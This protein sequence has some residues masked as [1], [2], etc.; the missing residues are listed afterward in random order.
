MQAV[1]PRPARR[2]VERM[3][4]SHLRLRCVGVHVV[5]VDERRRRARRRAEGRRWTSRMPATP[6]R[7]T[8]GW[9]VI[10]RAVGDGGGQPAAG[11]VVLVVPSRR[12]GSSWV[13]VA[14]PA[15]NASTS[16]GKVVAVDVQSIAASEMAR[17][18]TMR[19]ERLLLHAADACRSS[20]SAR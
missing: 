11:Q 16:P 1:E 7:T 8:S 13:T 2:V 14:K 20:T 19:A 12:S 4:R 15:M 3:A 18:R 17:C 9:S 5:A 6:M 10:A